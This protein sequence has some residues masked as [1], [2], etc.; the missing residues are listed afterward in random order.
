M[1]FR[2]RGVKTVQEEPKPTRF[3]F[4]N[5]VDTSNQKN[6]SKL[7][8]TAYQTTLP[9]ATSV[10]NP[11]RTSFHS[12]LTSSMDSHALS[13]SSVSRPVFTKNPELGRQKQITSNQNISRYVQSLESCVSADASTPSSSNTVSDEEDI[14][15]E[16]NITDESVGFPGN[17][18]NSI[19]NIFSKSNFISNEKIS[20]KSFN[21]YKIETKEDRIEVVRSELSVVSPRIEPSCSKSNKDDLTTHAKIISEVLKKYP[22]LVKD[23]KNVKLKIMQKVSSNNINC[24]TVCSKRSATYA[25]YLKHNSHS[26]AID[27]NLLLCKECKEPKSFRTASLLRDHKRSVHSLDR[28]ICCECNIRYSSKLALYYHKYKVHDIEPPL[29]FMFPKCKVCK[30][31]CR[32]KVGLMRH[33]STHEDSEGQNSNE[34]SI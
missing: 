5:F 3:S 10:V 8:S 30:L 13:E 12:K 24:P 11:L 14:T 29:G 33:S 2:R 34:S 20:N 16:V 21:C 19:C 7:F 22:R 32:N 27:N 26:R 15:N 25:R 31:V 28:L 9:S 4:E 6:D 18:S 23:K 17:S 1:S